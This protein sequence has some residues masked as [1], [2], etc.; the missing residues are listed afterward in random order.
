MV[1]PEVPELGGSGV[2][3]EGGAKGIAL[4][5]RTGDTSQPLTVNYK[6]KGAAVAGVDYKKLPGSVTI[7]AGAVK[8]KV[9]VK[10]IDGSPSAGVLKL[11]IQLLPST[12]GSYLVGTGTV[13]LK[14]IGK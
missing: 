4:V 7:P 13:K 6:V 12:D 2:A 11:K 10:P 1:P 14:L 8:A 9:K 5:T 3:V